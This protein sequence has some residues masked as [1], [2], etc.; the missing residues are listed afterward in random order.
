MTR[1]AL[2]GLGRWGKKLVPVI[3]RYSELILCCNRQEV[4]NQEWL[5]ENYPHIR[6]SFDLDEVFGNS[7]INAVVIATPIATHASLCGRTL[8]AGKHVFVEKPLATTVSESRQLVQTA[9][10]ARLHLFVGNI[11]LF[12]PAFNELLNLTRDDPICHLRFIWFKLGTFEESLIWNLVSHGVA[13][14]LKVFGGNPDELT[15]L[16]QRAAFTKMDF[17]D[18]RLGFSE[19][20]TCHVLIDRCASSAKRTVTATTKSGV[21]YIWEEDSLYRLTKEASYEPIY[22]SSEDALSVEVKKFLHNIQNK[23][24][25]SPDGDFNIGVV[26]V[27]EELARLANVH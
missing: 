2:I 13:L 15:L 24:R 27:L 17:I 21:V 19:K 23:D 12:H 18:V 25:S 1:V 20:R 9:R 8:R 3:S 4:R 11:L 6:S 14:A 7:Q 5:G 26:A 22:K 10:D 16:D